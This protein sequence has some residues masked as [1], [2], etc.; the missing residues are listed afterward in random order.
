MYL[1]MPHVGSPLLMKT[2]VGHGSAGFPQPG[3]D[4][5]PDPPAPRWNFVRWTGDCVGIGTCEALLQDV[6]NRTRSTGRGQQDVVNVAVTFSKDPVL[7]V[8]KVGSGQGRVGSSPDGIDCDAACD[9][10]A[11]QPRDVF[12]SAL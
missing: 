11:S 8:Q 4:A 7:S 10:D 5:L 6:V 1:P 12:R 3:L 2:N 9:S